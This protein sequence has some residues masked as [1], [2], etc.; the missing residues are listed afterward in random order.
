MDLGLKGRTAIVSGAS[1]GLG[2]ATAESLAAEGANVTMF[3]RRRDVLQR[4]ADRIGALAVRGDVTN[5]RDLEAVVRR[6]VE[7][8]GGIDILVWNAGG[9]PPGPAA[10]M[11]VEALEEAVELLFTPAL[12]LVDLCLPHLVESEGGRILLFTSVAALEPSAHLALS[13][14]VRPGVTGWAKTLSRELG[15]K[16]IT[17]NCIAPGRIETA[18]LE[19]LYPGGPTE[20]DL[21]SIPVGR[22]GTP[23]EFGDVACFLAS[24]RAR[25]VTGT[26]VVVDGGLSRGLF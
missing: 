23:E 7:A 26:T 25:Y 6:T 12:R 15:P 4:E 22:W 9:P 14:A 8:F 10:G 24:D 18:R 21:Q 13:N 20:S 16:G 11:A 2:L 5:P 17:V 1:S 3:A 19:Q